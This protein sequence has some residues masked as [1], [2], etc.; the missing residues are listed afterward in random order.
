VKIPDPG[1]TTSHDGLDCGIEKMHPEFYAFNTPRLLKRIGRLRRHYEKVHVLLASRSPLAAI[2]SHF[3]YRKRNPDWYAAYDER[4]VV[5]LY[6][7]SHRSLLELQAGCDSKYVDYSDIVSDPRNALLAIYQWIFPGES[8]DDAKVLA[9]SAFRS[10]ERGKRPRTAFLSDQ[11][12][13]EDAYKSQYAEIFHRFHADLDEV[14]ELYRML[15]RQSDEDA[16]RIA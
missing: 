16:A 9:D 10:T 6:K 15:L 2:G 1:E 8:V 5:D 7:S 3:A 11:A 12:G 4:Q 14:S 13:N